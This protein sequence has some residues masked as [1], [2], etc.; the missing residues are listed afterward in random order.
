MYQVTQLKPVESIVPENISK[1]TSAESLNYP[2]NLPKTNDD[3]SLAD[4]VKLLSEKSVEPASMKL[5]DAY[6]LN[7]Y[8]SKVEVRK[9]PFQSKA[10]EEIKRL[11]SKFISN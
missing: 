6:N 9:N 10:D 5:E 7:K 4:E 2:E 3:S 11:S 8:V 1:E